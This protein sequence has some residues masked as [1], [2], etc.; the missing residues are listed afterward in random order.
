MAYTDGPY[1]VGVMKTPV[2]RDDAGDFNALVDRAT[3]RLEEL[4][5]ARLGLA[6]ELFDFLGPPL[7]AVAGTVSPL[8][9]LELGLTEK[10]ERHINFLLIVT[11]ADLSASSMS[12]VLAYPSQLTN[13]AVV[14]SSRLRPEFWGHDVDPE[15]AAR[16]L[17]WLM[18][19]SLGHLLNLRHSDDPGNVMYDIGQ[20]EDLDRM[21]TVT[22]EQLETMERNLPLEAHDETKRGSSLGFRLRQLA[23]NAGVIARATVRANPLKL[24][25]RLPTLTTA[26]LSVVIVLFFSA[27]MWDVAEA[28]G[29]GQLA[30]LTVLALTVATLVL[31]R[32]FGFGGMLDRQRLV[33]ESTI[34]T[35]A[36]T[37]VS[38]LATML[39]VYAI[40][41]GGTYLAAVTIFPRELMVSWASVDAA[42]DPIDHFKLS[43]FLASMGVLT[44]SLGGRGD[45]KELVRGVLFLDEET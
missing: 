40:F 13:V 31:Y 17:A 3:D 5:A 30:V 25:A 15:T 9:Y 23:A 45:S 19:H 42:T 22:P 20:V 27:E 41:L 11:E 16:R 4:V 24:L 12:Y 10:L 29:L 35:E 38:L 7:E 44:G 2:R 37:L 14:S 6:I 26:A 18:L 8:D 43:V 21:A 32:A 28:V 33:A 36:T 39:L 34:V 1:T